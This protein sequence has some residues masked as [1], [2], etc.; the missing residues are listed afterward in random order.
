MTGSAVRGAYSSKIHSERLDNFTEFDNHWN[1]I[2]CCVFCSGD[3][4]ENS[5]DDDDDYS[6][7][8]QEASD[9]GGDAVSTAN[10]VCFISV[11]LDHN[12]KI[13]FSSLTL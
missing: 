1:L 11:C 5:S 13:L 12:A 2:M 8:D 7:S 6:L 4:D 9:S 3:G 10:L